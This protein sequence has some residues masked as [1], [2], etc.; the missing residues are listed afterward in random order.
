M[1]T[2]RPKDEKDLRRL[3][4]NKLG[5][6]IPEEVWMT[7]V[8]DGLIEKT[9]PGLQGS[10]REQALNDFLDAL[11]SP[12]KLHDRLLG[13][14]RREKREMQPEELQGILTEYEAERAE[15]V[16]E[17]LATYLSAHKGIR[18]FREEILGGDRRLSREEVDIFVNSEEVCYADRSHFRRC[19]IPFIDHQTSFLEMETEVERDEVYF[20]IKYL[21]E[22]NNMSAQLPF[23]ARFSTYELVH[24][25]WVHRDLV[26]RSIRYRK[27]SLLDEVVTCAEVIVHETRC[28]QQVAI[29]CLLAGTAPIVQPVSVH[30]NMVGRSYYQYN[31][32]S[33]SMVIEPWVSAESVMKTYKQLQQYLLNGTFRPMIRRNGQLHGIE[34]FRFV[35]QQM[36]PVPGKSKSWDD[37]IY[38]PTWRELSEAWNKVHPDRQRDF[39]NFRKEYKRAEQFI[40]LPPY[41]GLQ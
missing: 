41:R 3:A 10:R 1:D 38:M 15:A 22:P 33:I 32:G 8:E 14:R 19:G 17:R 36:K 5:R 25:N 30:L 31:T 28:V 9:L 23:E 6:T 12:L 13:G 35:T 16:A 21:V 2:K 29:L 40:M 7:Q 34:I 24:L 11:R 27:G 20:I 26:L 37:D 39:R 18:N 4:E